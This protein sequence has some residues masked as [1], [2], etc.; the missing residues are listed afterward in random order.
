MGRVYEADE[1]EAAAL[2]WAFGREVRTVVFYDSEDGDGEFDLAVGI[3]GQNREIGRL[4][5]EDPKWSGP[6]D[7]E[8]SDV[9]VGDV[10]ASRGETVKFWIEIP[11]LECEGHESLNGADMGATVFCDGTCV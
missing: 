6:D 8:I 7:P 3:D 4:D 11:E 2:R 9:A 10:P 5:P 1:S